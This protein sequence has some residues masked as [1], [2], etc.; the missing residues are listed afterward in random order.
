[1]AG[2]VLRQAQ[3]PGSRTVLRQAQEPPRGLV[4]G[5]DRRNGRL[6]DGGHDEGDG[7]G[8]GG[9]FEGGVDGED[10]FAVEV[11]D[12]GLAVFDF[13]EAGVAFPGEV[14][15]VAGDVAF[16]EVDGVVG[17]DE[18]EG[19]D[20]G[21]GDGFQAAGGEVVAFV[22]VVIEE[23]GHLVEVASVEVRA[24][25][26]VEAADGGA[27]LV[28]GPGAVGDVG[29]AGPPEVGLHGHGDAAGRGDG[30]VHHAGDGV[31]EGHA[32]EAGK[33]IGA[34]ADS[35]GAGEV[36]GDAV[37][38]LAE[39]VEAALGELQVVKARGRD[40]GLGDGRR[41]G[42]APAGNE[43]A[44]VLDEAGL[45]EMV[46]FDMVFSAGEKQGQQD[47]QRSGEEDLFHIAVFR[48]A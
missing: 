5:G 25:G 3:E 33:I 34:A 19:V 36:V 17:E 2:V 21:E 26:A 46:T 1:M 35:V 8:G 40:P 20:T 30:Q 6:V 41:G 28:D 38:E 11:F 9:A 12:G 47:C 24:D 15:V 4:Q 32:A 10:A 37:D 43:L 23:L 39:D 42:R 27:G 14:D 18:E 44:G 29:V 16:A 48:K 7:A 45:F 22:A 13:E 31:V